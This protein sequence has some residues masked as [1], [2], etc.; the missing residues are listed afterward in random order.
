MTFVT[1]FNMKLEFA[2]KIL[3]NTTKYV[4]SLLNGTQIIIIISILYY[5]KLHVF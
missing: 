3:S 2:I 1:L 5:A 4:W